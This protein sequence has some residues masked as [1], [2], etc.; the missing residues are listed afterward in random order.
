MRDIGHHR[1]IE[2]S[3]LATRIFL[4]FLMVL[5]PAACSGGG[6]DVADDGRPVVYV[7]VGDS[8]TFGVGLADP[9]AEGFPRLFRQAAL[10]ADA[11]LTNLG[12]SGSTVAAAL[13]EQLPKALAAEPTL[14]TLWLGVNDLTRLVPPATYESQLGDLVRQLR[15]DGRTTVL[16]ANTPALDWV[17]A[18]AR[19]GIDPVIVNG[20]VDAYNAAIRRVVDAHGA[21][22]VDLHAERA[23][24][25]YVGADGLHPSAS[26]HQAI[27]AA[28][29]KAYERSAA[30]V[31]R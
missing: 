3:R 18:V 23:E 17:P 19:L 20:A 1:D 7:A 9:A 24:P 12:V 5:L 2:R 22:L 15:R 13:K 30:T 10:P 14:V 28:F 31:S 25:R 11:A 26:G 21:V 4:I 29:A 8:I 16:V 6:N 27:A